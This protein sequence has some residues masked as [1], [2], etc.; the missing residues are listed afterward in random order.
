MAVFGIPAAHEDDA[1]RACRAALEMRDALPELGVQARIGVMTGEAVTGTEERLVTGDAVNTAARLEQAA[2]PGEVLIGAPTLELVRDAVE[3]EPVRLVLK[4]QGRAGP[5]TASSR[6]SRRRPP[7]SPF[8]GRER[9]HARPRE[10]GANEPDALR[11]RHDR[12]R[13]QGEV[14]S[15]PGAASSTAARVSGVA[16]PSAGHHLLAAR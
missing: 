15:W 5:P 3:A 13:G 11:A 1:L 4:G 8:V 7:R 9:A 12:R 2:P 6:C 16:F 10:L 14:A